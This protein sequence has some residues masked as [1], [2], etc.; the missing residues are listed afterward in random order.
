M[1]HWAIVLTAG[2]AWLPLYYLNAPEP[3]QAAEKGC[4]FGAL[5]SLGMGVAMR[6]DD[7]ICGSLFSS[8]DVEKRVRAE[9][10]L[11]VIRQL[12]KAALKALSGEF[13]KLYLSIGRVSIGRSG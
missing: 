5:C 10:P 8:I 2:V 1:I 6:G 11:R 4:G 12:A 13:A 7:G 3:W 9:H